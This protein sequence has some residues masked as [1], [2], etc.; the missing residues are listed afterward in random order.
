MQGE[1]TLSLLFPC[2]CNALGFWNVSYTSIFASRGDLSLYKEQCE[3]SA[4]GSGDSSYLEMSLPKSVNEMVPTAIIPKGCISNF[5]FLYISLLHHE[6]DHWAIL[7]YPFL[8]LSWQA[9]NA[10]IECAV[11]PVLSGHSK[12]DKT[13]ILM[14]NSILM[15]VE[16][17][18]ECSPL[19]HS[20]I[21]LTYIKG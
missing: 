21:L 14:T 9:M 11:K 1:E 2:M 10:L 15:K 3:F 8:N 20:A 13:N 18:A 6:E 4:L 12:I 19:E 16:S 17:I 7:M 5:N